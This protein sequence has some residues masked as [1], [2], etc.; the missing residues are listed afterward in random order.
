M[1]PKVHAEGSGL[2][3]SAMEMGLQW[4]AWGL[5]GLFLAS[6]LAATLLPFSSEAMLLAMV[7]M[8]GSV[9]SLLVV[10]TAGNTLGGLVNYGLGRWLPT[11]RLARGL[12]LDVVKAERWQALV[13]RRGAWMALL[14]WLPVIGDPIAIALGL[15]RAPFV[16]SA[17]FML[18]GKAARY[19]ILL[20][21]ARPFLGA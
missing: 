7:G 17:L 18:F 11:G 8:G 12:G 20:W 21:G 4:A 10:A 2:S 14:C 16:P 1:G 13:Q 5:P 6:F 15:F 3:C 9:G 19:A